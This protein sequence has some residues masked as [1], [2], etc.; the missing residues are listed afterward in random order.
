[1]K[2]SVWSYNVFKLSSFYSLVFQPGYVGVSPNR[3]RDSPPANMSN[4]G[5]QSPPRSSCRCAEYLSRISDLEGC[6]ALLKRQAKS[7]LDQ[8]GKSYSLI[9][10]V[11]SLKDQLSGLVAQ[12]IDTSQTYLQFLMLHACLYTICFVF[13]YTSCRFYAFSRT[14]LLTRCHSATSLFSAVFVFQKSYTGKIL[15]IGQ[16]K[17]QS[18]YFSRHETESKAETEGDQAP[19]AP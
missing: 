17:S 12:V 16:N 19:G 2:C 1:M 9:R 18:S 6:L 5:V 11:S 8:A 15:G 7:A 3:D 13:C 10:Q 4:S 14:N